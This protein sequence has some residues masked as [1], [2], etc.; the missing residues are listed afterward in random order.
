[1]EI[2]I[3]SKIWLYKGSGPWHFVTI[4]KDDANEIKKQY[5]WPRKGFGSIPINVK[6]GNT[7][8]KT[9]VFPDKNST[10]VLP[11]K[12]EVRKAEDIKE[13]DIVSFSI[14]VIN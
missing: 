13:G 4:E 1:M 12:K 8:W 6:I 3:K 14:E 11:I 7:K 10:F 9:S 5:M 2:K